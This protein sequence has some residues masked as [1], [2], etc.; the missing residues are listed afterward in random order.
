MC[1]RPSVTRLVKMFITLE[2]RG[3]F[4]HILH[5]YVCQHSLHTG[6]HNYLFR[7]GFA[8]QLSS[9]LWSV[10]ENP[11]GIFGSNYAYLFILILS[12]HGYAKGWRGFDEHHFGRSRSFSE[13]AHHS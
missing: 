5:T 3:I 9:L 2:P 7:H 1:V 8:G 12:G 11:H 13:N 10:S 6:M 4:H